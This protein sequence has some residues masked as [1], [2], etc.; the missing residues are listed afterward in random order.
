[1]CAH[2]YRKYSISCDLWKITNNC[3]LNIF[4]SICYSVHPISSICHVLTHLNQKSLWSVILKAI[5]KPLFVLRGASSKTDLCGGMSED[6]WIWGAVRDIIQNYLSHT[7]EMLSHTLL[8]HSH[9]NDWKIIH[10]HTLLKRSHTYKW[11]ALLY[12]TEMLSCIQLKH[13]HTHY[14]NALSHTTETLSYILLKCSRTHNWN[15]LLHT[16]YFAKTTKKLYN[17]LV[18][19]AHAHSWNAL[20]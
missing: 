11:N 7:C 18:K 3:W 10:S 20:I 12:T 13:S 6:T 19:C 1:M 17:I 2:A 4:N 16:Q 9:I 8:K 5:P 15:A 14:W